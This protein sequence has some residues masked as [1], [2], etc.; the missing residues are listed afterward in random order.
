MKK[1]IFTA[2]ALMLSLGCVLG[3]LKLDYRGFLF[4]PAE[5]N[6]HFGDNTRYAQLYFAHQYQRL[7]INY[8]YEMRFAYKNNDRV[9]FDSNGN[10]GIGN[11]YPSHKLHVNGEVASVRGILTSD[12]RLKRDILPI[13]KEIDKLYLLNGK[14]YFKSPLPVNDEQN[15]TDLSEKQSSDVSDKDVFEYGFLAQ[16][17][18]EIYPD[19]VSQDNE[20]YHYVNYTA[21]IPVIV[22][23]LKAQK[24]EIEELKLGLASSL[25]LG[26]EST[27]RRSSDITELSSM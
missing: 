10:V 2:L 3:Q 15:E 23:A 6:L 26:E 27:L 24:K 13:T 12:E 7:I 20:G 4:I 14:S 19:L 1:L 5:K 21:L 25:R 9:V 18:K 8:S 17:L 11:M 22:E 16:E